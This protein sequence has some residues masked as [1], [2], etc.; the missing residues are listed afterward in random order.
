VFREFAPHSREEH[1]DNVLVAHLA[2]FLDAGAAAGAWSIADSRFTA[3]FLFHGFH[4]VVD[5]ALVLEKRVN[6]ARLAK[7]LAD[8]FFR[9][10]GLRRLP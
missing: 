5:D 7:K 6:R 9:A 4:G 10:V 3:V 2:A 1:S 8:H